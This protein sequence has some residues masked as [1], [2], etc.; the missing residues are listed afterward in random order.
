MES[1]L[2]HRTDGVG[3]TPTPSLSK[4]QTLKSSVETTI[5]TN[6]AAQ[7]TPQWLVL[8]PVAAQQTPTIRITGVWG[9]RSASGKLPDRHPEFGDIVPGASA[10]VG[11]KCD[12]HWAQR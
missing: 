12:F 3:L 6:F 4:S 8:D 10:A 1:T 9:H 7:V 11:E 2:E 5:G